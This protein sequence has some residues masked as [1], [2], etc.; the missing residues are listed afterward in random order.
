MMT[1]KTEFGVIGRYKFKDDSIGDI[2][3]KAPDLV[4]FGMQFLNSE[5][6]MKGVIFEKLL[7]FYVLFVTRPFL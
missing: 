3:P 4:S 7:L 5:R 6:S 2:Y 1:Y